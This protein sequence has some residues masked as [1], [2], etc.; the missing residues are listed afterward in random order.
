MT[1]ANPSVAPYHLDCPC[2][3]AVEGERQPH[4]QV[5]HC[6]KCGR[7]IQVFP[8]SPLPFVQQAPPSERPPEP[9]ALGRRIHFWL[10]PGLAAAATLALVV[11]LTVWL[12]GHHDEAPAAANLTEEQ[13]REQ[14]S[15]SLAA[16]R[17]SAGEG[18]YHTASRQLE[19]ALR[20][21]ERFPQLSPSS[22]AKLRG[23]LRQTK[24]LADLVAESLQEIVRHAI[25][26]SDAE[27]KTA[28]D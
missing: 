1:T 3:S 10:V 5:V 7:A 25:G 17:R 8:A 21:G 27:W 11:G 6:L 24:L 12:I 28:F 20:L 15:L 4:G 22:A 2:G 18:A 16:A 23:E 14:F 9:P 19:E 26:L 13:A